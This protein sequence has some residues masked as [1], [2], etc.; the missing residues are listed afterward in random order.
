ML[1][2]LL[3]CVALWWRRRW[4]VGVALLLAAIGSF[5]DTSGIAVLIA[6]FTVAVHRRWPAVLVVSAANL[7]GLAGTWSCARSTACHSGWS[8]PCW[9]P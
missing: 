8:P 1:L 6:L 2:G 7:V 3:G 5:S 9:S 4:P